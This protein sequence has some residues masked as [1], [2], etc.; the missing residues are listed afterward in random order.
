MESLHDDKGALDPRHLSLIIRNMYSSLFVVI[1]R[2]LDRISSDEFQLKRV[3]HRRTDRHGL[4]DWLDQPS[5]DGCDTV[6]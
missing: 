4:W 1:E 5:V 2:R 6:S 3:A